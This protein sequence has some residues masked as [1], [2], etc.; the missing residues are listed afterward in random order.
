MI[1]TILGILITIGFDF[2]AITVDQNLFKILYLQRID[3][4]DEKE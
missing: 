2:N 3:I 4:K 1:G